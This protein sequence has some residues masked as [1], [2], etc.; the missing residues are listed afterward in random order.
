MKASRLSGKCW[1]DIG[2]TKVNISKSG[3]SVSTL[4]VE[5]GSN[6]ELKS[7]ILFVIQNGNGPGFRCDCPM[8]PVG[9]GIQ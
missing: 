1:K 5:N 2:W 4:T 6:E 3:L 7:K 8:T 9:G